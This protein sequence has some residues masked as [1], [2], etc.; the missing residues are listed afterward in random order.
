MPKYQDRAASR[1]HELEAALAEF[2]RV[3]MTFR[4]VRAVYVFGSLGRG[5][6]G[7]TS[8]LDVLVVRDT[9]LKGARRAIDIAEATLKVYVPLDIVVVTPEEFRDSFP[10]SSLGRSVV[11]ELRRV[12]GA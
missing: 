5:E 9:A 11:H 3:A 2:V 1:R 4:D 6:V 7:P 10:F 8:D 12:G